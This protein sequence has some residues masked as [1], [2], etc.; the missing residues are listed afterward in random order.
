M[1][2][3]LVN[4]GLYLIE[5]VEDLLD[6]EKQQHT[7]CTYTRWYIT[8]VTRYSNIASVGMNCDANNATVQ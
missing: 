2:L 8:A 4:Q 3:P 5:P 6:I 7:G 1:A